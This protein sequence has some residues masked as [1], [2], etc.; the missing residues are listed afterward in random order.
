MKIL[1]LFRGGYRG[2]YYVN[3][4][5]ICNSIIN[6][7]I[8][9]LENNGIE[10]DVMFQT[11]I[12]QDLDIFKEYLKP[13]EVYTSPGSG[14]L[15]NFKLCMTK[16]KEVYD[17]YDYVII[18]RFELIYKTDIIQWNFFKNEGLT[19]P[20]KEASVELWDQTRNGRD[21]GFYSDLIFILSKSHCL[22]FC[23]NVIKTED[24]AYGIDRHTTLH[25]IPMMFQDIVP[26]H[27]MIDG[28]HS[29]YDTFFIITHHALELCTSSMDDIINYYGV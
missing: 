29:C 23:E 15:Y 22:D 19:V 25:N 27:T 12:F 20:Y 16:I 5:Q 14:Q 24:K 1:L 11:Y 4:R 8:K 26:I 7:I 18:L 9:P 3:T 17:K 28:F 21:H 2:S 10:Y 13:I 6:K